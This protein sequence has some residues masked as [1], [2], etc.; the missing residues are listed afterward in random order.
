MKYTGIL[1]LLVLLILSS[2]RKD[3]DDTT[4]TTDPYVPPVIEGYE[5]AVENVTGSVIGFV[6]DENDDPVIGAAVRMGDMVLTTDDFGHF[7]VTDNVMNKKGTF[8]MVEKEGYF[9]GSRRFF[10]RENGVS[11]IKVELLT[12]VFD[13]SFEAAIG[14]TIEIEGGAAVTFKENSIRDAN[15]NAYTGTVNVASK[16][17]DPTARATFDQMPGNLQGVNAESKEV[18]LSTYG[19]VA[20]ELEGENGE[21]LNIAEGSTATLTM[22]VPESIL[23]SAPAEIPLWS[24]NDNYGIWAQEGSAMLQGNMYVGEVSHFSFWNCDYPGELVE[25]DA[26]LVN[27][28]EVGVANISVGLSILDG[29]SCG[30]GYSDGYGVVSGLIPAGE[31]LLMEVYGPCGNV[32][33]TENIGP[34]AENTSLGNITVSLLEDITVTGSLECNGTVVEEGVLMVVQNDYISYHYV[35]A[36]T[37][38]FIV[39]NC[40]ATTE[41]SITGINAANFTQ[42]NTQT[43]TVSDNLDL[44]AIAVCEAELDNYIKLIVDGE[45]MVYPFASG[46]SNSSGLSTYIYTQDSL[47]SAYIGFGFDG[48]DVGDYSNANAIEVIYDEGQGWNIYGNFTTF[49]VTEYGEV[50][51]QIRGTFSGTM[52]NNW[53]QQTTT[54]QLEGEFSALRIQ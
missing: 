20:V 46:D 10:P 34:F 35:S 45:E 16:W 9:E 41:L 48:E 13:Q 36:S 37:F 6:A 30:F 18:V 54:V 33:H 7:F 25:F 49:E 28:E 47:Q 53:N 44:G 51:E 5:P 43:V 17:L 26:T 19:M 39:V 50:G 3:I 40:E 38:E 4:T 2:C 29:S 12:K 22:P 32:V 11:R 15:G 14:E 21:A 42:S 27:A 31:V 1:S 8:V 52:E 23:A 24:F